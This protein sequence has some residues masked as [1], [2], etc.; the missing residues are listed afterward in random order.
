[1]PKKFDVFSGLLYSTVAFVVLT[2]AAMLLYP[3]GKYYDH[4][5]IGY[6]FWENFFSDLGRYKTY[7]GGSKYVSTFLFIVAIV[8]VSVIFVV[9]I[10]VFIA[11]IA[12]KEKYPSIKRITQYSSYAYAFLL[13]CTAFTPYDRL[14]IY[15]VI[16]VNFSFMA[17]M[18]ASFGIS[19]LLFKNSV[20]PNQYAVLFFLLG[21][22]LI[23]YVYMLFKFPALIEGAD[24]Y[25]QPTAQKIVAY[26]MILSQMYLATGCRRYLR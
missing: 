18:I 25:L 5:S 21:I 8:Q 19:F 15:H 2:G 13:C 24:P 7:S 6:S 20:F 16:V 22:L 4:N 12:D 10:K 14:F 9:F 17:M 3:G 23:V 1:M 11:K 26:T